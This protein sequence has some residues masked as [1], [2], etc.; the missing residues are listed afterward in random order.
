[1]NS[2]HDDDYDYDYDDDDDDVSLPSCLS[3][4]EVDNLLRDMRCVGTSASRILH[5]HNL[6]E[7]LAGI[8]IKNTP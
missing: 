4:A 8:E 1:M 3:A 6:L 7:S 2:I 5:P